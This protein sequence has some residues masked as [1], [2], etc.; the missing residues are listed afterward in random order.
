MPVR[1]FDLGDTVTVPA[2]FVPEVQ[3]QYHELPMH[4][5]TKTNAVFLASAAEHPMSLRMH[6]DYMA[7]SQQEMDRRPEPKRMRL[8]TPLRLLS[9]RQDGGIRKKNARF[10]VLAERNRFNINQVAQ[11]FT[12]EENMPVPYVLLFDAW[13]DFSCLA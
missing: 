8:S 1:P 12:N 6:S 2:P 9:P 11:N 13:S 10:D 5:I 4:N 3:I 7:S